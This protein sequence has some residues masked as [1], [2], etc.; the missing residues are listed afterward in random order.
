MNGNIQAML[1]RYEPMKVKEQTKV[2][3]IMQQTALLGLERS[4]LFEMDFKQEIKSQAL[5]LLA[6]R[7]D[8]TQAESLSAPLVI[9]T[10]KQQMALSKAS[11][12]N[13]SALCSTQ[14]V[15]II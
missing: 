8:I 11:A 2:R 10:Y 9:L 3:E 6:K 1:A 12:T 5:F 13:T 14:M 7:R 4:G 15:T